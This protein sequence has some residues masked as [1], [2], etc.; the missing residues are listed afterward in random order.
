MTLSPTKIHKRIIRYYLITGI[1]EVTIALAIL[2]LFHPDPKNA[3]LFG[4]SKIRL[5]TASFFFAV[6]VVFTV[7]TIKAWKDERWL[8]GLVVKIQ[9]W[10]D[11]LGLFLPII[12]IIFILLTFSPYY[13]LLQKPV[14]HPTIGRLIPV[15][16]WG[17]IRCVQ[18]LILMLV[19]RKWTSKGAVWTKSEEFIL[20][21]KPIKIAVI[22]GI[23]SLLL[24]L[25]NISYNLMDFTV[26]D[27]NLFHYTQKMYVDF[28]RNI[29]TYYSSML[30]WVAGALIGVISGIKKREGAAYA[31]HWFI[32]AL[33]F[34]FLSLDEVAGVHEMMNRP[35]RWWLHPQG[36]FSFQWVTLGIPLL[37]LFAISYLRFFLHLPLKFRWLFILSAG[38]YVGGALGLE[39]VG[40]SYTDVHGTDNLVYAFLATVEE[41]LEMLGMSMFLFALLDYIAENY[42]QVKLK[43]QQAS[44]AKPHQR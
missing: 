16:G 22:L 5:A 1:L 4:Y 9:S 13:Y 15:I 10:I 19:F 30:L 39:M 7:F 6:A 40:A 20:E 2:M 17:F 18:T 21:I 11:E 43:V 14:I 42:N 28:E 44:T 35:M 31:S 3:W 26:Q 23:T 37:I 36:I 32:L 27:E 41:S 34:I 8:Q 33:I 25:I 29:P 38:L 12:W 24:I